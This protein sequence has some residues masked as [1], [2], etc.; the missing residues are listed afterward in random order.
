MNKTPMNPD[1][2]DWLD[3]ILGGDPGYIND[4]GFTENVMHRLRPRKQRAKL[5]ITILGCASLLSIA[6]F[7]LSVPN[8]IALYAGFVDFLYAESVFN[9]SALAIGLYT[10]TGIIG[11]W[12]IDTDK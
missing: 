12:T 8:P 3:K 1:E 11:Y 7:L 10:A 4:D 2:H 6:I 5:R 9:L